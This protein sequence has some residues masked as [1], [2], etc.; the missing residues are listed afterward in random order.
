MLLPLGSCCFLNLLFV[1]YF[2]LLTWSLFKFFD[3]VTAVWCLWICRTFWSLEASL[4]FG[5]QNQGLYLI[6]VLTVVSVSLLQV[7]LSMKVTLHWNYF[8]SCYML[9]FVSNCISLLVVGFLL[10]N[11]HFNLCLMFY[12]KHNFTFSLLYRL[13]CFNL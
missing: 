8:S 4:H 9:H 13:S 2:K 11:S 10:F 7:T 5:I 3:H 12:F 6:L 1:L